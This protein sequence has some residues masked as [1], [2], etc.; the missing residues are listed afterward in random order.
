[1]E[2]KK[3][4]PELR[5]K[6]FENEWKYEPIGKFINL[7]SEYAKKFNVIIAIEVNFDYKKILDFF[8]LIKNKDCV[9]INYDTGNSKIFNFSYKSEI[10]SYGHL[11]K[12]V[13][14]KDVKNKKSVPL[15]CGEINFKDFFFQLKKKKYKGDFILQTYRN[16]KSYLKLAFRQ[17]RFI[18]K[19]YMFH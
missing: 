18:K 8:K 17:L 3:L 1:M 15:G 7:I 12:H 14:I 2:V 9:G 13:H 19:Q 4:V 11:I 6:G 5:F 10:N 16:K